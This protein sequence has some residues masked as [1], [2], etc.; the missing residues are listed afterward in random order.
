MNEGS[1][2]FS[3][4]V[5]RRH[6]LRPLRSREGG[7]EGAGQDDGKCWG[8]VLCMWCVFVW[9]EGEGLPTHIYT[10]QHT[11]A[12]TLAKCKI[13]RLVDRLRWEVG[14]DGMGG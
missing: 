9:G 6:C 1:H 12:H 5:L 8:V 10:H 4:L 13:E 2:L 14:R 11:Q 3:F 7:S